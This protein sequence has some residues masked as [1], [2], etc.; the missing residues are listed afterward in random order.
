MA[1]RTLIIGDVHGCSLELQRLWQACEVGPDDDIV[2]VGDLVGKGPASADVVA[3]CRQR[4]VRSVMGNHDHRLVQYYQARKAGVAFELGDDHRAVAASLS[5]A[6]FDYL[7]QLPLWLT[8]AAHD[9]VVVHA[10]IVPGVPLAEQAPK[11]LLTVRTLDAQGKP[12]SRWDGGA[13]W[14]SHYQGPQT[15]YFGHHARAGLQQ[16]PHALGLD[17]GCVYGRRLTGFLL[18]EGR[19][20][21][22]PAAKR[23]VAT[24]PL[25]NSA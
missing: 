9:A 11:T 8:L 24:G 2:M 23:Y 12:S 22:V 25:R 6:D 15:I 16:H 14:A 5:D 18:P 21:S 1:K 13:L 10:G 17:T 7:E 3:L 19:L 4:G 20:V